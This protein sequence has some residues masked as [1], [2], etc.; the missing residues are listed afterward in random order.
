MTVKCKLLFSFFLFFVLA[1]GTAGA[2]EEFKFHLQPKRAP[3]SSFEDENHSVQRL[4]N[5][6]DKTVILNVWATYCVPCVLELQSLDQ[7]S[8]DMGG[9]IE[10][11]AVSVGSD[12]TKEI[13]NFFKKYNIKYLNVYTDKWRAIPTELG[14]PSVPFTLLINSA[15]AEIARIVG[16]AEFDSP[17]IKAQIKNLLRKF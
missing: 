10:V 5:F 9:R 11:I 7:L 12:D 15:G 17:T 3:L 16:K 1:I 2:E 6:R 4:S 8:K 13:K 14:I